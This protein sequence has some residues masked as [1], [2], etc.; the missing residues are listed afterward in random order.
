[1]VMRFGS[2]PQFSPRQHPCELYRPAVISPLKAFSGV[3]EFHRVENSLLFANLPWHLLTR[4]LRVRGSPA[5]FGAEP[6]PRGIL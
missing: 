1:M 3:G 2:Y 6:I 5:G 4:L